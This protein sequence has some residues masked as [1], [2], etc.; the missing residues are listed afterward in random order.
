MSIDLQ[1]ANITKRIAAWM[2][3]A[4]AVCVIAVGIAWFLSG[5]L[6]YDHYHNTLNDAYS[7]YETEYSVSFTAD[8]AAMSEQELLRYEQAYNALIA[9]QRAMHAYDMMTSMTLMII[10]LA[11][12]LGTGLSEFLLPLLLGNGQTVGKKVFGLGLV[13]TD[14][15]QVNTLQLF[16]RAFLGKFAIETMVPVYI[17]LMIFWG[18]WGGIGTILLLA[19]CVLQ[20]ILVIATRT[21]SMIHDLLAGTAVV[22][23]A[24][25][26]IFRS[27]EEL[28]EYTKRIHAERA[29]REPY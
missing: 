2:L 4:I 23:I 24:S 18:I 17:F 14:G 16:T 20:I 7:R 10:T 28:V 11:L 6:G 12:L 3:D 1:R 15:I 22:D 26:H 5:V 21:N 29:A 13:R 25:Q 9:D 27:T 19:L 8:P